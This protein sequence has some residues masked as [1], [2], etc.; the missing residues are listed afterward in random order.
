MLSGNQTTLNSLP[1]DLVL[2]KYYLLAIKQK[3]VLSLT[4]SIPPSSS[5][6]DN[7]KLNGPN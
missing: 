1:N 3:V 6:R 7:N 4:P 2:A 5:V